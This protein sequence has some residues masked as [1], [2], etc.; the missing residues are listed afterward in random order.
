ML[1][2]A[3]MCSVSETAKPLAENFAYVASMAVGSVTAIPTIGLA[4]DDI[5]RMDSDDVLIAMTFSPYRVE[6]VE[7]V[8]MASDRG[9]PIIAVTDSW[10][11]PIAAPAAYTFVVPTQLAASVLVMCCSRCAA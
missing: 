9:I 4:I 3:P 8:K 7:A 6:I 5:A 1:H 10:A 2:D 11:A